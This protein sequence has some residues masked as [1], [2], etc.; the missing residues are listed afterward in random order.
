MIYVVLFKKL[1]AEARGHKSETETMFEHLSFLNEFHDY[2][3]QQRIRQFSF[4]V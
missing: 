3:G 4:G 2:K 1:Y